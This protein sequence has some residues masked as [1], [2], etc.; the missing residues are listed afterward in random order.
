MAWYAD[1]LWCDGC[2]VEIHWEPIT[3]EELF[4]CCRKCINGE[5]CDCGET[6]EEY[7]SSLSNQESSYSQSGV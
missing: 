1:T 3:K 2:G 5:E 4:F 6:Q 7:P